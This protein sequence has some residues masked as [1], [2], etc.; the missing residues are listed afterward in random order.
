VRWEGDYSGTISSATLTVDSDKQVEAVFTKKKYDLT[1]STKGEGTVDE[2]VLQS[3]SKAYEHGS[4]VELTANAAK[5]W[6]FVEWKGAV[7][8]TNKPVQVTVKNT[9]EVTAVIEKTRYDLH[10]EWKEERA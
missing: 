5:G 4:V 9:S 10:N 2:K 7:T 1:V 6:R 3:K 8:G